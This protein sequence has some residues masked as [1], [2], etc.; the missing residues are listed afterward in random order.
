MLN[1]PRFLVPGLMLVIGLLLGVTAEAQEPVSITVWMHNHEPRVALDQERLPEF[2]EANPDIN[3]DYQVIENA[4]FSTRLNTAFASG[5]GPDVTNQFTA[6][7]AQYFVQGVIAPVDAAAMGYESQDDVIALYG[8]GELGRNLL[9]GAIFNDTLY[10]VPTELSTYACYANNDLWAAAGLDPATDFPQ[11]WEAMVDVAEQ[12]TVRDDNGVPVQRG[13]DFNWSLPIFMLLTFNP[14]VEQLGSN[15]VDEANYTAHLDTPEVRQVM[16]YWNDWVNTNN[17][18]GPQYTASR[19][20]FL[21]GEL[22]TECT[23][24]NWGVPLME[25]NSINYSIHN[26]PVWAEAVNDNGLAVFAYYLLVNASAPPEVQEAGW[27]FVSWMIQQPGSYLDEAGLFQP[28]AS[29]IESEEFQ[30][31]EIMPIF[32][33]LLSR[34]N[35]HPRIVGFDEVSAALIRARDRIIT[36]GESM[37]TVLP[38]AEAEVNDILARALADAQAATGS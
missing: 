1:R 21:A 25:T 37:D 18:G 4:E 32:L 38:E 9:A 14:M 2:L 17:L 5:A 33:D 27:R 10:G 36:G 8:E 3:V 11:T 34:S 13:F 22:A 6:F 29:Y 30:Q 19:D 23:F 15:M 26:E 20:A 24:G 35:Y 7:I 31:N 12:L 28:I 16:T